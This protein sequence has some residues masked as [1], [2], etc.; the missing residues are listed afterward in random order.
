MTIDFP[1]E[2]V[3]LLRQAAAAAGFGDRLGEYIGYLAQLELDTPPIPPGPPELSI[4][5]K[6]EEEIAGMLDEGLASG[7]PIT[8][9]SQEWAAVLRRVAV[10]ETISSN[11]Q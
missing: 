10:R 7:P 4:D 9:D 11:H 3:L 2:L 5:G 1:D 8:M 6:S